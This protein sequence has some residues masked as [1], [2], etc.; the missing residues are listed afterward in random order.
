MLPARYDDDDD[1]E[2]IIYAII[3]I[4]AIMRIFRGIFESTICII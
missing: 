1:D 4:Y 3:S 2:Y